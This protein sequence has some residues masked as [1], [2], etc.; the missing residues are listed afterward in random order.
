[1]TQSRTFRVLLVV[2]LIGGLLAASA[3]DAGAKKK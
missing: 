2:A 1:M 3:L